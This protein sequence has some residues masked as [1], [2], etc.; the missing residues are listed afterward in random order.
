MPLLIFINTRKIRLI[1]NLYVWC[2]SPNLP[3]YVLNYIQ[4]S[5][6]SSVESRNQSVT[7]CYIKRVFRL[8]W[9][10]YGYTH[11]NVVILIT[12]KMVGLT[13]LLSRIYKKPFWH[14]TY[15]W[16]MIWNLIRHNVQICYRIYR[17]SMLSV[18]SSSSHQNYIIAMNN[19]TQQSNPRILP[20]PK[21]K[22]GLGS[23]ITGLIRS[24]QGDF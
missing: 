16:L 5:Y 17:M 20:L 9:L 12:H 3:Q 4:G 14:V 1:E 18:A 10:I 24:Q 11:C 8:S 6:E 7:W 23:D 13:C 22:L 15:I 21:L 19:M 2:C